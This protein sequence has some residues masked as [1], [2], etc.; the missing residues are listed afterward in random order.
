MLLPNVMTGTRVVKDLTVLGAVC[1]RQSLLFKQLFTALLFS[2]FLS[3][4]VW[5]QGIVEIA[6]VVLCVIVVRLCFNLSNLTGQL[7][8][9]EKENMCSVT[10]QRQVN[11][12]VFHR[13]YC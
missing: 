1:S 7:N 11:F 10:L 6:F 8:S 12:C 3:L 4:S 5:F 13:L 9:V 2:S